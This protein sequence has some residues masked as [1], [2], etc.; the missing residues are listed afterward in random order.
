MH[1]AMIRH[2]DPTTTGGFVMAF[3]S[4]TF[5]DGRRIALHGDEATCGICQGVFKIFGSGTDATEN[6][7]ATVLH[8]DPVI[9]PCGKNKV[10]VVSDPGCHVEIETGVAR[11]GGAASAARSAMAAGASIARYDEQVCPAIQGEGALNGYPYFIETTDGR[12][13][14]GRIEGSGPLPRIETDIADTYTVYWG[15]EALAR[16]NGC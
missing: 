16:Q 2:G 6:G 1:R 7:R 4:T 11:P 10:F 8:G 3:S 9:C 5:D 12:M 15:D 14:L 13:F